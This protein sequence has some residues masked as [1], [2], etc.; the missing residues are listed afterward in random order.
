METNLITK[1]SN[2]IIHENNENTK[3]STGK[4]LFYLI[5]N[6]NLSLKIDYLNILKGK[7][8]TCNFF[9]YYL[10]ILIKKNILHNLVYFILTVFIIICI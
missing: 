5:R 2:T 8:S 10:K 6:N 3:V 4:K 9:L 1:H 7:T